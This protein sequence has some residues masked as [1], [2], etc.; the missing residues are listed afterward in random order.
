[1]FYLIMTGFYL[2][3]QTFIVGSSNILIYQEFFL[4][5]WLIGKGFLIFRDF[6]VQH[7]P[8]LYLLLVPFAFDKS[9]VSMKLFY[10]AVQTLNLI[11]VLLILKKSRSKLGFLSGGLLYVL[12][13]FYISD[14]HL[15]DDVIATSFYLVIYYLLI[16]KPKIERNHLLFIGTLIGL[17]SFI[18]PSFAIIIL[19]VI[20]FCWSLLPVIPFIILW[21]LILLF[22]AANHGLYQFLDQYIFYNVFYALQIKKYRL[23][24]DIIF[25]KNSLL[26]LVASIIFYFS[27]RKQ[28][29]KNPI[30]LFL[31]FSGLLFF[32][33]FRKLDYVIFTAFFSIFIGQVVGKLTSKKLVIYLFILFFYLFYSARQTKHIYY[34][35]R[36]FRT[37][38][39]E[40]PL[41]SRMVNKLKTFDLENKKIYVLGNNAELYYFLEKKPPVWYYMVLP[42]SSKYYH[43]TEKRIIK[44]LKDNKVNLIV[45]PKPVDTQYSNLKALM[46]YV[47]SNYKIIFE[48]ND[49]Q[50]LTIR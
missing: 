6:A 44:D 50:L 18:K 14:N 5:P 4:N 8:F 17:V 23:F 42:I 29:N 28:F 19:P 12:L 38:Y 41:V 43:D 20:I 16:R 47:S 36:N 32:T 31:I 13:N 21:F 48:N 25:L 46:N 11:L 24:L 37:P 30:I 9:L 27:T 3:L 33:G 26:M 49:F 45:V 1:M 22:Y 34:V 10:I 35:I 40:N 39:M 15:W 2:I 7:G